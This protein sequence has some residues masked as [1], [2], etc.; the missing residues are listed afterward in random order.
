MKIGIITF[1]WGAN[2]GAILQCYALCAYLEKAFGAEVEVIHYLPRNMEITT[3]NV[4]KH[5]RTKTFLQKMREVKK[6][7]PRV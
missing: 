5:I 7:K 6:Q 3:V 1:H 2:H 4:I